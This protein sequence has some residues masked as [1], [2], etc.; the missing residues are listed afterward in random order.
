MNRGMRN[1]LDIFFDHTKVLLCIYI[2][3]YQ[4]L[5]NIIK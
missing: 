4:R 2:N 5:K 3:Y 1:V